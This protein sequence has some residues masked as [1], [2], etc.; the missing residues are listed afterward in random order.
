MS[1]MQRNILILGYNATEPRVVKRARAFEASGHTVTTAAFRRSRLRDQHARSG[2]DIDLGRTRDRRYLRRIGSLLRAAVRILRYREVVRDADLIY[3][4][5][6]DLGLLAVAIRGVLR[7]D[8]RIVYEVGDVQPPMVRPDVVGRVFR[9]AERWVL[10]H[11][12]VV[13]VTSEGF[14]HGYF[15]PYQG[16]EGPYFLLENK[17][18]PA[19][20][21]PGAGPARTAG[22]P[23]TIGLF[24]ALRCVESWRLIEGLAASLPDTVRFDIRGYP[25]LIDRDSFDR[26]VDTYE[27]VEYGGPYRVP[28]D[29][30]DMYGG[31][32]LVW[33]FELVQ[34]AHN[35]RWL[36]PTRLYEGGYHH[37]PLIVP[38]GFEVARVVEQLG[39]GWSLP[40]P[41]LESLRSFLRELTPAEYDR[42]RAA[43]AGIPDER[44]AGAG[45]HARLL[46]LVPARY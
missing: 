28:D 8:A 39:V 5:N 3:A 24:G 16:Y 17:L 13:T 10:R 34:P 11:A 29:L 2:D 30:A 41:Y 43:F 4:F 42:K 22:P 33:G 21:R 25:T 31:I 36:L 9:A 12:S 15:R 46:E 45:D 19:P 20:P 27:N 26:V 35:S 6:L 32:D 18:H 37:V 38:A 44:W 7:S 23:W 1:R 40:A 14:V